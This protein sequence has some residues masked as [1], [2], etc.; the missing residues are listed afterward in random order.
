MTKEQIGYFQ[1]GSFNPSGGYLMDAPGTVALFN[2]AMTF[3]YNRDAIEKPSKKFKTTTWYRG[4][5]N[6]Q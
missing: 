5:W 4:S 1:N 6:D 3:K 2:A